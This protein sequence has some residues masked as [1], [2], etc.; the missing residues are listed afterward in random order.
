MKRREPRSVAL[1]VAL[2]LK[3]G[4]ISAWPD[5]ARTPR[6]AVSSSPRRSLSSPISP[7]RTAAAQALGKLA[8]HDEALAG[9]D[10]A[11]IRPDYRGTL[12]SRR[13]AGKSDRH[14]RRSQAKTR[15]WRSDPCQSIEQSRRRT[16]EFD[17]MW[18]RSRAD[19][20][21]AI[22]DFAE[23]LLNRGYGP[24]C[25]DEALPTMIGH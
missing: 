6:R 19:Q 18:N 10:R 22:G 8:R 9:F 25:H 13:D 4:P 24:G 3:H 1:R 17:R 15:R 16:G 21:L 7:R 2:R 20:A 14:A 5:S 23:A 12:Q 11:S